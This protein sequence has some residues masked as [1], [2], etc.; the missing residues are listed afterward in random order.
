M[1]N[2]ISTRIDALTE[3]L[4]HLVRM[5][6]VSSEPHTNRAA[7][8]WVEQQLQGL[9]LRVQRVENHDTPALAATTTGTADPK[10]PKLW[11]AAHMDVVSGHPEDFLPHVQDG[12]LYGRGSHDMKFAIATYIALFQ[13]L[14]AA[15]SDYDLGLIITCDEELGGTH[16]VGWLVN[17]QG[18]RGGA[19]LL[20]DSSTPWKIE[21]GGKGIMWWQISS[22]GRSAHASK[23][24][25]GINAIDELMKFVSV[26]RAKFPTEP[27]GNP[28]H[29]HSTFNLSTVVAGTS[30]NKVPDSAVARID[31]RYTS[32]LNPETITA[33]FNDAAGQFPAITVKS[34]RG[35]DLP[36][37]VKPSEAGKRFAAIAHEIT[38]KAI[39]SHTA[40]GSSDARYFAWKNVPTI[41]VGIT[42]SGYHTSPEWVSLHDLEQF[43]RIT[44]RFVTEQTKTS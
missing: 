23:P 16:G 3:L 25:Q 26:I 28:E 8:D 10:A 22:T 38:G 14:G 41:N 2:A 12:R 40:H 19:V 1:P 21:D 42:G 9:P 30:T 17:D 5:P 33:W 43:Y 15:L 36:Y 20:P 7:L 13:E 39:E 35:E 24:W 37:Q 4:T 27:C 34:M 44:H 31:V 18:Y 29:K 11:L 32:D 6:T